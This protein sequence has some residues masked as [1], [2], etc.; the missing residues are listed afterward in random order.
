MKT[1]KIQ[2]V[3]KK[4]KR[5][6]AKPVSLYPLKPEEALA[7]FIQIKPDRAKRVRKKIKG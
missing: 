2:T 4:R 3:K 6:Y 5:K 1:R 7:A